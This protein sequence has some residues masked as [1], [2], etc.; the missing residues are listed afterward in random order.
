MRIS[1][2]VDIPNPRLRPIYRL[3]QRMHADGMLPTRADIR[4]EDLRAATNHALFAKVEHPYRG[5][6]SIH[7]TNT[8]GGFVNAIGLSL[9]D[10]TVA[11]VLADLGGTDTFTECFGEYDLAVREKQCFYNEGVFPALQ[12]DWLNHQRLVM[13]LGRGEIAEGLFVLCD[14]DDDRLGVHLPEALVE[15]PMEEAPLEKV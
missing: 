5:M 11:Q 4:L 13:P 10:K 3:W 9:T 2:E 12:K 8:G 15:A 14:F 7:F 1:S 6:E